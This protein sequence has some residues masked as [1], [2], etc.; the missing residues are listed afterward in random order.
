MHAVG[1]GGASDEEQLEPQ[2]GAA[3]ADDAQR[4][5]QDEPGG[6]DEAGTGGSPKAGGSGGALPA[7]SNKKLKKLKEK[8]DKRG[9]IYISRIPPHMVSVC[10]RGLLLDSRVGAC[11]CCS[12]PAAPL[13]A[14]APQKPQKLR[15]MLE[16]YGEVG[17]VY[18]APEDPAARRK[19]K[20]AGGNSGKNFTEGWVE[21]ED[22]AQAKEVSPAPGQQH[23]VPFARCCADGGVGRRWGALIGG[24]S[25]LQA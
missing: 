8:Y 12:I 17:R 25:S 14:T 23:L 18:L 1:T 22:K 16:Q 11:A 10:R 6:A 7:L 9:I 13:L 15:Q 19:R 5:Q 24:Q 21:F 2:Q 3:G 4:E 20:Q